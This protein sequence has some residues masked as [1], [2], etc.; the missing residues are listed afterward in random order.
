MPKYQVVA[1]VQHSG[2]VYV[3][4]DSLTESKVGGKQALQALVDAGAVA[5]VEDPAETVEPPANYREPDMRLGTG[6][7]SRPGAFIPAID[8]PSPTNIPASQAPTPA[9]HLPTIPGASPQAQ[10]FQRMRE[11]QEE[12]ASQPT[13][14]EQ[15]AARDKEQEQ[16][17]KAAAKQQQGGTQDPKKA[18]EGS[19]E[20]AEQKKVRLAQ[21]AAQRQAGQLKE[22]PP[23][24]QSTAQ[25]GG[26]A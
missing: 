24:A 3:P 8:L 18:T 5:V 20:T 15:R 23:P 26:Q 14:E 9:P 7:P 12:K 16:A 22:E 1:P 6:D 13:L 4:G 19:Q 2:D 17:A 25:G 11:K 10:V 21:E